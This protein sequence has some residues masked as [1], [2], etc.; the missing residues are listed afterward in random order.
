M[1]F[2]PTAI[3]RRVARQML[4]AEANSP[5]LLF[6]AGL[7]GVTT[8][9]VLAC[10]A[11]LKMHI[12]IEQTQNDLDI[13]RHLDNPNYSER[14]RQKDIAVIYTRGL[15]NTGKLYLPALVVGGAAV[16]CLTK[17][18]N[19]L[20]ER[21]LA[22]SAAYAAVDEAF[23]KYRGRVIEKYGEEEDREFRYDMEDADV[24][25]EDG[26]MRTIRR[27]QQDGHS[28]YARW[29]DEYSTSWSKEP[30]YNFIF[31]RCRQN[32]CNDLLRARGHLFLNEVYRELGMDH[33]K[34]G[35][36]VGWIMGSEGDNYVD[37]G[38]WDNREQ[39]RDF[40]NGREGSILLDFNVDGVIFDKIND[41]GERIA[42]Q[43]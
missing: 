42:W 13:A 5:Q 36:V 39:V 27:V 35:A 22:L 11:T 17:S 6:V 18:H 41:P 2:V 16:G 30:E 7:A 12:V 28:M 8:S 14:D 25:G 33:T 24:I 9:T 40:V 23:A 29:F 20:T 1:K 34:A 26:K 31:L 32:W 3:S 37:F 19:M 4:K 38:L 21:N 15:L 43:S 10:R